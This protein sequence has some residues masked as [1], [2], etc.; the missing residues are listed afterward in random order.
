LYRIIFT[1]FKLRQD[2]TEILQDVVTHYS[3][4]QAILLFNRN[5]IKPK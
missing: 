2:I 1:A 3:F 4:N 5:H